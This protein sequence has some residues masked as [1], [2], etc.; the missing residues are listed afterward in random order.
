MR[1]ISYPIMGL[2]AVL[3]AVGAYAGTHSLVINGKSPIIPTPIL[4]V[5]FLAAAVYL[6]VQG[7]RVLKLKRG[8][9]TEM[10]PTGA[11]KV[12]VMCH[13][14]AYTSSLFI[15]VL[16]ALLTYGTTRWEAET[17]RAL[18]IASIY[19]LVGAIVLLV[20]ALIVEHWCL[21]DK[22]NESGSETNREGNPVD[23]PRRATS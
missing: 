2:I 5:I 16:G 4:G 22:D 11:F 10:T 23:F 7:R 15:G 6:W 14:S 21:L 17:F 8:Q 1:R 12:A 13:S 20:V 9:Y 19:G 3:G 18:T